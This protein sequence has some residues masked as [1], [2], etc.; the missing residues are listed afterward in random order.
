MSF[1][2]EQ[3]SVP[4]R[5]TS[6][7]TTLVAQLTAENAK[8]KAHDQELRAYIR[9]KTNQLLQAMGTLALKPEELD[10]DT[11]IA[12]DPIGTVCD[13]FAQ[14]LQHLH[15]TNE[16]LTL[17]KD[18][19]QAIF[20][21]VGAGIL[22][23]DTE[24]KLNAYNRKSRELFFPD[25]GDPCGKNCNNLVCSQDTPPESCIFDRV[26]ASGEVQENPDFFVRGRHYHVIGTP[27]KNRA[28]EITYII[29]LYTD[30]TE[31][32]K[33]A[34]KIERLAYFDHLTK[35]PNRSLLWDRLEQMVVRA[36][37]FGN[38]LGLFFLDIDRFKAIND[39]LGHTQGD[40]LLKIIADRLNAALRGV[41]TIARLG[42]DE[43]V[44]LVEDVS[45]RDAAELVAEKILETFSQPAILEGKELFA[46]TSIGI[47]MFPEDGADP[48]TLLKNA[49]AAMYQAKDQGRNRYSFYSSEKSAR[50][51]EQLLLANDLRKALEREEFILAY[52]PQIDLSHGRM[53]GI[54]ALL[55]WQHPDLGVISPN[56]FI[57]LAEETGLILPIGRWAL[58]TACHQTRIIQEKISQP[59]RVAVNLSAKQFQDQQLVNS[60]QTILRKTGLAPEAL[61]LE[62]TE[63]ILMRNVDNAQ[64][65]LRQLKKMAYNWRSTISAPA[66]V[67][68]ATCGTSRSIT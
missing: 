59:L 41:D 43:F 12:V 1:D 63:S 58:E 44:V 9:A 36:N 13:A 54:E 28:D 56:Q 6:D 37:R 49:D 51:L 25:G 61:E 35:L 65:T 3:K 57:P 16:D 62:I 47:S 64:Q 24:K 33:N 30:T 7:S 34:A 5:P 22:V 46:T 11:L 68:S 27:I 21:A 19:L 38:K 39:T 29:L 48:D 42:G 53:I 26:L 23:V 31:R 45:D 60:V 40:Q 4:T 67:R 32:K 50:A 10:D 52:Q 55:R 18:E 8:I 14:V 66:T 15:T 17:A 2:A 20:D